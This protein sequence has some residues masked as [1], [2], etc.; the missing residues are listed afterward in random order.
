MAESN[1]QLQ[2]EV[3]PF[4]GVLRVMY[5][6]MIFG[7]FPEIFY[8]I[9]PADRVYD[10]RG[11]RH[12]FPSVANYQR[13]RDDPEANALR[14]PVSPPRSEDPPSDT[15]SEKEPQQ[16]A[17]DHPHEP[18]DE[19]SPQVAIPP[20]KVIAELDP[21]KH[22]RHRPRGCRAGRK[23]QDARRRA[24]VRAEEEL[25]AHWRVRDTE[26]WHHQ[27]YLRELQKWE[28]ASAAEALRRR[29]AVSH[30]ITEWEKLHEE[31]NLDL[32]FPLI[33]LLSIFCLR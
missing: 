24:A 14:R 15:D 17:N 31:E 9:I 26:H 16:H 11:Q 33:L 5:P 12:R 23:V 29:W 30:D 20:S 19:E 4:N 2:P 3:L 8:G 21:L 27:K 32:W 13:I 28:L 7:P 18:D 1:D 22:R 25:L 6:H 10:Y